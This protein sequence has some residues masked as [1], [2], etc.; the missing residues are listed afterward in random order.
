M[1]RSVYLLAYYLHIWNQASHLF[2]P[3]FPYADLKKNKNKVG[4]LYSD[5]LLQ[6]GADMTQADL[7][8]KE[9]WA[10]VRWGAH[11]TVQRRRQ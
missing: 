4:Y 8:K 3:S 1:S 9:I 2:V 6:E 10:G 5:S 7:S 11:L